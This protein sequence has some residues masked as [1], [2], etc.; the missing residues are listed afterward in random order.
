MQKIQKL[1]LYVIELQGSTEHEGEEPYMLVDN[2]R[3]G[4][5]P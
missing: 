1:D 5:A 4:I 3:L 2:T